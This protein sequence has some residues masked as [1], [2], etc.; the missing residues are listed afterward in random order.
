MTTT[1]ER[2]ERMLG[3]L[4]VIEDRGAKLG[5][6]R[7]KIQS[8]TDS[9]KNGTLCDSYYQI[10]HGKWFLSSKKQEANKEVAMSELM[11]SYQRHQLKVANAEAAI[12][13]RE[14]DMNL[15]QHQTIR[16]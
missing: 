12:L 6:R 2:L 1:Q 10:Q 7:L 5:Q 3:G 16:L 9:T 8:A 15:A 14:V 11:E 13:A 4:Y